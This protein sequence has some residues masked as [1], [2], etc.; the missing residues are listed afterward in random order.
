MEHK[1]KPPSNLRFSEAW[2]EIET[3][4]GTSPFIFRLQLETIGTLFHFGGVN[5]DW[6][7]HSPEDTVGP[8]ELQE[9]N[10]VGSGMD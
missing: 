8:E 9:R 10:Q 5:T 3:M 7:A 6:E 4:K 2:L 1:T